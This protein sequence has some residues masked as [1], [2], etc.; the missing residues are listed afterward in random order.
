MLKKLGS[1]TKDE[2]VEAVESRLTKDE[3]EKAVDA[4]RDESDQEEDED[5]EDDEEQEDRSGSRQQQSEQ[6]DDEEDDEQDEPQ[7]RQ[8]RRTQ[9]VDDTDLD[10][11]AE[12]EWA[13]P[14]Q[15]TPAP[16]AFAGAAPFMPGAR[17]RVDLLRVAGARHLHGQGRVRGGNDHRRERA[18]TLGARV[19]RRVLRRREGDLPLPPERITLDR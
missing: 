7:Q 2:L 19:P 12:L 17:V 4:V 5:D 16:V 15:P 10:W 6:R 13:P 18:R 8:E 14:P 11:N 3:I 9:H 1:R